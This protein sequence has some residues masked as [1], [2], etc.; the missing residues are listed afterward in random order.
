MP[1]LTVSADIDALMAAANDA[2]ARGELGGTTVGQSLFLVANPSAITFIRVNADNTV[3]LLSAGDFLTAIGAINGSAL[4]AGNLNA[5][6][7]PDARF[8]ATLPAASGAN[9]T[10][11]AI[12]NLVAGVLAGNMTLGELAG[13]IVLDPALSADGRWSGIMEAGTAGAALAFGQ[14]CYFN[15]TK[16][17]LTDATTATTGAYYKLGMCVLA[18]AADTDPTNML[19]FGKI[20]ADGLFPAFGAGSILYMSE[21]PGALDEMAPTATDT[22]TRV[23]GWANS[24]DEVFFRPSSDYMIHV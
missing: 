3:T 6:T 5:G 9:L 11:L 13:Q 23:I 22:V 21:T 12:A 16:W 2:A 20:R 24:A 19:L 10:N 15:G 14:L 7:V 8:P 4:N 17:L 18:A 1:N